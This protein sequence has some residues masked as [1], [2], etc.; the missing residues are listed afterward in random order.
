MVVD[1]IFPNLI[2]SEK[3][4]PRVAYPIEENTKKGGHKVLYGK[5]REQ[6]PPSSVALTSICVTAH[7]KSG[8]RSACDKPLLH[9]KS[10][11]HCAMAESDR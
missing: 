5:H 7:A 11:G 1:H 9:V 2:Y 8:F 10:N 6:I 3:I 4:F